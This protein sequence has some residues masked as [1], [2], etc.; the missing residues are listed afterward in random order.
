MASLDPAA[1]E[2]GGVRGLAGLLGNGQQIGEGI[3]RGAGYDEHDCE[4]R[5]SR[6]ISASGRRRGTVARGGT[7]A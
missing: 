4:L 2:V 7:V 6:L 3:C 1:D 5:E